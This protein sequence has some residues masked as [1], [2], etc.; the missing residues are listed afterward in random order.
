[1]FASAFQVA[2]EAGLPFYAYM[3]DLW[4][5][6]ARP[7]SDGYAI[8]QRWEATILRQRIASCA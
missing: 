7:G 5:E 2:R 3:H 6:N 8:A 4:Q 1:M